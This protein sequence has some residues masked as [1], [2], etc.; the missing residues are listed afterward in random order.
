M[1]IWGVYLKKDF[2]WEANLSEFI[3]NPFFL[4][5]CKRKIR[6]NLLKESLNLF[7]KWYLISFFVN[8]NFMKILPNFFGKKPRL[9][10]SLYEKRR[11]EF[12]KQCWLS[13]KLKLP[14]YSGFWRVQKRWGVISSNSTCKSYLKPGSL[15]SQYL[16]R[17]RRLINFDVWIFK[18]KLSLK[19]QKK[20]IT[21]EGRANFS[22]LKN[23]YVDKLLLSKRW[24]I[25]SLFY[26]LHFVD[27]N[28][29]KLDYK[30][31]QTNKLKEKRELYEFFSANIPFKNKFS[32][33]ALLSKPQA[34]Y[35]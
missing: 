20:N 32:K 22:H 10:T 28:L 12:F 2:F 13:S 6:E 33:K 31:L 15:I 17:V 4:K 35:T 3:Q 26:T 7:K 8:V 5:I 18:L 30:I 9:R 24:G 29:R 21:L 11:T 19:S 16:I 23:H 1:K 34:S 14:L 25:K 27:L